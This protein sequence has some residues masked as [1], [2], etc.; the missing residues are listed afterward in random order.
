MFDAIASMNLEDSFDSADCS[1]VDLY[2]VVE[3][4][5]PPTQ[6]ELSAL[7]ECEESQTL[8]QN[9]NNQET[10]S[11]G[12]E[13]TAREE[14][15][16]STAVPVQQ[17]HDE[18]HYS[19][20][21]SESFVSPIALLSDSDSESNSGKSDDDDDSMNEGDERSLCETDENRKI[22]P[23]DASK[24]EPSILPD[25]VTVCV[26]D[27]QNR[28]SQWEQPRET[29]SQDNGWGYYAGFFQTATDEVGPE[30]NRMAAPKKVLPESYDQ[31]PSTSPQVAQSS[32]EISSAAQASLEAK[33]GM[34]CLFA[35]ASVD[36][37]DNYVQHRGEKRRSQ[38]DDMVQ[39]EDVPLGHSGNKKQVEALSESMN[40][41]DKARDTS[42]QVFDHELSF[43][44]TKAPESVINDENDHFLSNAEEKVKDCA[45]SRK[46]GCVGANDLDET[47]VPAGI[48]LSSLETCTSAMDTHCCSAKLSF[49][50]NAPGV[51]AGDK[52]YLSDVIE[53]S[54]E[55]VQ[56]EESQ[57]S[58][59]SDPSD[60]LADEDAKNCMSGPVNFPRALVQMGEGQ[61]YYLSDRSIP[62]N[63]IVDLGETQN[64]YLAG[65]LLSSGNDNG[66]ESQ[67]AMRDLILSYSCQS[68]NYSIGDLILSSDTIMNFGESQIYSVS[69]LL[70]SSRAIKS[71]EIYLDS[72]MLVSV[73]ETQNYSLG[74]HP[75]DTVLD[76]GKSQNSSMDGLAA[77]S[78]LVSVGGAENYTLSD[79]HDRER[80]YRKSAHSCWLPKP[81]ERDARRRSL[82]NGDIHVT[83][84]NH[85]QKRSSPTTD[86]AEE[87]H[88]SMH[89]F[90][91][92]KQ[93]K[94]AP[95]VDHDSHTR[96][97]GDNGALS[98]RLCQSVAA[99]L[100]RHYEKMKSG[101]HM[102]RYGGHAIVEDGV[103]DSRPIQVFQSHANSVVSHWRRKQE[104]LLK[105]TRKGLG[106]SEHA[107]GDQISSGHERR[108]PDIVN[109]SLSSRRQGLSSSNHSLSRNFSLNDLS[110][111]TSST[112]RRRYSGYTSHQSDA[113]DS[114]RRFGAFDS[115]GTV[116]SPR[117]PRKHWSSFDQTGQANNRNKSSITP[118]KHP[119]ESRKEA[120]FN[121][122]AT[123]SRRKSKFHECPGQSRGHSQSFNQALAFY[124]PPMVS[125]RR[126]N[127]NTHS[128]EPRK[129]PSSFDQLLTS[130]DPSQ[131]SRSHGNS[132]WRNANSLYQQEVSHNSRSYRKGSLADRTKGVAHER[133]FTSRFVDKRSLLV[134]QKRAS[135]SFARRLKR[136]DKVSTSDASIT[137]HERNAMAV[138]TDELSRHVHVPSLG[139]NPRSHFQ[140]SSSNR[141]LSSSRLLTVDEKS[142]DH[143]SISQHSRLTINRFLAPSNEQ[144]TA[145]DKKRNHSKDM[146][147]P[148]PATKAQDAFAARRLRKKK[149]MTKSRSRNS[150]EDTSQ[151]KL[152]NSSSRTPHCHGNYNCQDKLSRG[153][154]K[155]A[156]S[157][158]KSSRG[159]VE[160]AA[161]LEHSSR[162]RGEK[163]R[164]FEK[165]SSNERNP[166]VGA[167]PLEKSMRARAVSS[168]IIPRE[169][170]ASR[171][172][173][174]S[175]GKTSKEKR[176]SI[177]K[178]ALEITIS[179]VEKNSQNK[180]ASKETTKDIVVAV[181]R[182]FESKAELKSPPDRS[183]S[184]E[185]A[186]QQGAPPSAKSPPER[187]ASTEKPPPV[188]T[189]S[190]EKAPP[191]RKALL[192]SFHEHGGNFERILKSR[193]S[194]SER[195]RPS[196][197]SG[198]MEPSAS[199]TLSLRPNRPDRE[200]RLHHATDTSKQTRRPSSN[201]SEFRKKRES[202]GLAAEFGKREAGA[203]LEDLFNPKVTLDKVKQVAA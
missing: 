138:K 11:G 76:L 127:S 46:K 136:R 66:K 111:G 104:P 153:K 147:G 172:R 112:L 5:V 146:D 158:G 13:K 8:L 191:D 163:S 73:G 152:R 196:R 132:C 10:L 193:I 51:V 58:Y 65:D 166:H 184:L 45:E 57:N 84:T 176:D 81:L 174:G 4:R 160:R 175:L 130:Y 154:S 90:P 165:R 64:Y 128:A 93:E 17:P 137:L 19:R 68:Q 39:E 180:T 32:V 31:F 79:E 33:S 83:F 190:I 140:R 26:T 88:W 15:E 157:P 106:S 186:S 118:H 102:P 21:S 27:D 142:S 54:D 122:H 195:Q 159:R 35:E 96:N 110:G 114:R 183:A 119:R 139:A 47:C 100:L 198:Q 133:G 168:D 49:D 18:H 155:G 59:I 181:E 25:N 105:V 125:R 109:E 38:H 23:L 80:F 20:K 42:V 9:L 30:T 98:S 61:N 28:K 2:A 143:M 6:R 36:E 67:D 7:F 85:D 199:Q 144:L 113:S 179:I 170:V 162:N 148:T 16:P 86:E 123:D 29:M 145:K 201:L 129:H 177:D 131:D 75:L 164:S 41:S 115:A 62:S 34:D 121:D 94:D 99:N 126:S 74:V 173:R 149:P 97:S 116:N 50:E 52:S 63:A 89:A 182:S 189:P 161:S 91:G 203:Y 169:K 202:K 14:V 197:L 95:K 185:K 101:G 194:L 178:P 60:A 151:V 200:D 3:G 77:N 55:L 171:D 120:A 117:H 107:K 53:P 150:A 87:G 44:P 108:N 40:P 188:R 12:N 71:S 92:E 72:S 124:D 43:T 78:G 187:T 70:L 1:F 56:L 135:G 48:N 192:Q 82:D 103:H 22:P 141:E 69:E 24:S 134:S 167:A 37:S 156:G